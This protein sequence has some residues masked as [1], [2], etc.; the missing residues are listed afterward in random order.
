M[1]QNK[2]LNAFRFIVNYCNVKD[3][4]LGEAYNINTILNDLQTACEKAQMFDEQEEAKT[5]KISKPAKGE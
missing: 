2:Y 3:V 4:P 5:T 1:N